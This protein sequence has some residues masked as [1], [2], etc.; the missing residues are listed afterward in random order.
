MQ[1][2]LRALKKFSHYELHEQQDLGWYPT[3][4]E[5]LEEG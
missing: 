2:N 5:E 4:P 3:P 1:S